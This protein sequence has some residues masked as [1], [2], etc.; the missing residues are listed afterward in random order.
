MRTLESRTCMCTPATPPVPALF[1]VILY[2]LLNRFFFVR[3]QGLVENLSTSF[4][5]LLLPLADVRNV[6]DLRTGTSL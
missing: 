4:F 1:S 5:F 3:W 6:G 2:E